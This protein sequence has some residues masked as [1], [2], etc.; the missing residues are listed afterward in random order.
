M[1]RLIIA[2]LVLGLSA[3]VPATVLAQS[4]QRVPHQE[5][6]AF[7][8]DL[9]VFAPSGNGADRLDSAPMISGLYEFYVTPRISLR[10]S[11]GWTQPSLSGSAIDS[12]R[13]VPIRFDVNY[14]WE[15][16]KW[17]PFVGTG[18]GA[19]WMQYRRRGESLGDSATKLGFNL[20]G[21]VEYFLNRTL[22]IKGEGRYN[23]V[24][25]FGRIDPSG[26]TFTAGIKTYF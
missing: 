10:P 14:N 24:Q 11:I 15:G 12:V 13:E 26:L 25:D 16:G 19:Y 22:T 5:S 21:G 1:K 18:L 23:A 6:A 20:G 9:G 2:S 17:H 3:A 7:G 8:L 4:R